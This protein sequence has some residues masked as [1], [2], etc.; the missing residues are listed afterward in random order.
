MRGG[1][2]RAAASCFRPSLRSA[3]ASAPG[4]ARHPHGKVVGPDQ[5]AGQ[6]AADERWHLQFDGDE[7]EQH[8]QPETGRD[9]RNQVLGARRHFAGRYHGVN[10]RNSPPAFVS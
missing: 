1:G 6:Q 8:R 4:Q 10:A 7:S 9:G 5:H 3:H 2:L